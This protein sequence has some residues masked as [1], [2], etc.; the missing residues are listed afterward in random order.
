MQGVRYESIWR[1][2]QPRKLARLG[3]DENG[4]KV[5]A[6]LLNSPLNYCLCKSLGPWEYFRRERSLIYFVGAHC[7][8]NKVS[9]GHRRVQFVHRQLAAPQRSWINSSCLSWLKSL[10]PKMLLVIISEKRLTRCMSGKIGGILQVLF[11]QLLY[12]VENDASRQYI[13]KLVEYQR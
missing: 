1:T 12:F 9:Q 2:T 7:V 3:K 13:T 4:K 5:Q 8:V 11:L 6:L 10:I